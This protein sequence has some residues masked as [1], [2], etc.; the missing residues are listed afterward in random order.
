MNQLQDI[1]V[2]TQGF[3]LLEK[4]KLV[5]ERNTQ[6]IVEIQLVYPEPII[7]ASLKEQA[8]AAEQNQE[9]SDETPPEKKAAAHSWKKNLLLALGIVAVGVL[10]VVF[11]MVFVRSLSV[12][13]SITGNRFTL[14]EKIFMTN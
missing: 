12:Y 2:Q 5:Q 14:A 1:Y 3:E 7:T 6:L 11:I 10:V 9:D 13:V 4:V 8:Q